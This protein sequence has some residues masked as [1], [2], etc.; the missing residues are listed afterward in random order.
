[1]Y[2]RDDI[3]AQCVSNTPA[4]GQCVRA[5][6][7]VGYGSVLPGIGTSMIR[8]AA[9]ISAAGIAPIAASAF[10]SGC[11]PS[12]SEALS[13]CI[14]R[15]ANDIII[16]PYALVE[17][18]PIRGDLQQL[19]RDSRVTHPGIVI[20]MARPFGAHSGVA[21]VAVQRAIE[22][23]YA[24]SHDILLNPHEHLVAR[25]SAML[26]TQSADGTSLKVLRENWQPRH[27]DQP[28]GL[29]LVAH[30]S[31]KPAWDW[32]I[33]AAAEWIRIHAHYAAVNIGFA[34]Q[35][36]PDVATAIDLHVERGLR[37]LVL[38]PFLLQLT[39]TDTEHLRAAAASAQLRHPGLHILIADYLSYDRQLLT[40]I[41]DRVAEAIA[42][43]HCRP[44][45][46]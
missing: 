25:P 22:A 10:L 30:G 12:F 29:V 4:E 32:P 14:A 9:R 13:S 23:D 26:Y 43:S 35:N 11:R 27:L 37:S 33:S 2:C 1:M 36:S 21:R 46:L 24:A 38:V 39:T 28:A 45:P 40:V 8:L 3:L 34:H 42:S 41:G 5:V 18:M 16:Q 15:G 19:V 44:I 17:D 20:R 31:G 7:L 6:V